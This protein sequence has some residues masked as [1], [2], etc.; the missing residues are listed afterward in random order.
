MGLKCEIKGT[1]ENQTAKAREP[2][3]VGRPGPADPVR[4]GQRAQSVVR[5]GFPLGRAFLTSFFGQKIL[6]E[7]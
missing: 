7:V 1:R 2:R 4:L 3:Q 5:P 6:R